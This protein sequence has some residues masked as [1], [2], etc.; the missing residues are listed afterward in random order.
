M[1]Q[2]ELTKSNKIKI[3][4]LTALV[5]LVAIA[6]ISYAYFTIQITGNDTASSMRLTTANMSLVYTDIE[7]RSGENVTPPWSSTPKT[8]TVYNN[9]NTTAYYNIIWRDLYNEIINNEL[10]ISATCSS[11]SGSCSNISETVIPTETTL[12]HNIAIKNNIEIEPGETHTY[13]VTVTFIDT[14]SNQNYN[15]N[16][17]FYGT[18]NIGEGVEPATISLKTDQ[19]TI[20]TLDRGD[21]ITMSATRVVQGQEVTISG[22]DFYVVSTNATETVLLAKYN[23][24][25]GDIL[26]Y[27]GSAYSLNK[28]LTSSDTGYG[29]QNITAKGY[30]S[31]SNVQ[32]IGVVPFSGT[33]YWDDSVCQYTG[34]SWGCTGTSDLKSEYATG[35]ASYSGTPYPIVYR[36]SMSNI[37]PSSNYDNGYGLAQNNGYTIAY[38]VEEYVNRLGINGTGRLL[39]YEEEQSLASSNNGIVFNGTSYWLGSAN[40]NGG[41]WS[42]FSDGSV[43]FDIFAYGGD[44]GVRPVIVVNT[45]DIVT[46]ELINVQPGNINIRP[47]AEIGIQ[48]GDLQ[49]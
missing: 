31:G 21:V 8:I 40:S 20:G 29:L 30:I 25:V 14:G 47:G 7:I 10:V 44:F 11:S 33:N 22:E 15:Q 24:Y 26:D 39:T 3:I 9:G 16:K 43:I 23:L 45:S 18:I 38:Y 6:G 1:E 42:V 37:A 41:V 46:G 12:A 28:T 48:P 13:T 27:N 2:N 34:T 32:Y 35:G 36:S 49:G 19:G 5:F 17:E 4:V